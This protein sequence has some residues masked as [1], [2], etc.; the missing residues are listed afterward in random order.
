MAQ[1]NE[2]KER[3]RASEAAK[4]GKVDPQN[5]TATIAKD[6][7]KSLAKRYQLFTVPVGKLGKSIKTAVDGTNI[8][9]QDKQRAAVIGWTINAKMNPEH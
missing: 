7:R 2:R 1:A 3:I 6:D 4:F 5:G 9:A 8:E